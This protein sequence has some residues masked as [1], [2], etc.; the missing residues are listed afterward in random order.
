M[1]PHL[2]SFVCYC[3]LRVSMIQLKTLQIKIYCSGPAVISFL[4]L[5]YAQSKFV[6]LYL[7]CDALTKR[8]ILSE[9][10][11]RLFPL[12]WPIRTRHSGNTWPYNQRMVRRSFHFYSSFTHS[13]NL[14]DYILCCDALTKRD[15]LS[16]HYWRLSPLLWTIRTR[17]GGNTWPYNQRMGPASRTMKY[18][19][20]AFKLTGN[21]AV[22][23]QMIMVSFFSLKVSCADI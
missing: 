9:H 10:Y 14:S 16:E 20:G 22:I 13:R 5:I 3:F 12:L 11:W 1:I 18:P 6:R 23:S 15:I 21:S 19:R 7:C 2:S 17:H 8:D 4:L